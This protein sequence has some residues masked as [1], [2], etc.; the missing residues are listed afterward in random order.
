[1]LWGLV[2]SPELGEGSAIYPATTII[3]ELV[4]HKKGVHNFWRFYCKS[5]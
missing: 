1:M 3:L 2:L 5:F 4:E